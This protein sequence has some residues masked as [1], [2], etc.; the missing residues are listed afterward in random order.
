MINNSLGNYKFN[1]AFKMGIYISTFLILY[2]HYLLLWSSV[3]IC[4]NDIK[5]ISK[6]F[7]M[8]LTFGCAKEQAILKL[9]IDEG[10]RLIIIVKDLNPFRSLFTL[11]KYSILFSKFCVSWFILIF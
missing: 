2:S 6:N 3:S 1:N 8:R 5:N 10:I 9:F 11:L 7:K 4:L